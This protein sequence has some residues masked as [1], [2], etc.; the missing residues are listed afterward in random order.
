[1]ATGHSVGTVF[2]ELDLDPSRYMKGQ[3]TLLKEAQNG[4]D[5]LEKNFKNLQ[6]KSDASYDLMRAQAVKSLEAIK[7][8]SQSTAN[9]IIRAEKAKADQLTR[10]NEQQY[11]KQ[12]GFME[13]MKGGWVDLAAK[14][15]LVRQ[16]FGVAEWLASPF[17]MGLKAVDEYNQSVASL[18]AMVTTFGERQ[19]GMS[20]ADQ[21]VDALA[22][23]KAMIP[24][25]EN[26]AAKTLLSGQETTALANAFARSGVF[27]DANNAKQVESFTRI[28]NA[29]PLMTQG[30]EI[31]RQINTEIRGLMTGASAATNMMLTTL[32]AIDPEIE[33]H[34]D[35]WRKE[36]TVL[37]HVGELLSGFGPAT[38]LLENNWQAVKTNIETI[39]MQ[40]MRAMMGG[41]YTFLIDKAKELGKAMEG[42]GLLF[43]L[44]A[45]NELENKRNALLKEVENQQKLVNYLKNTPA[46]RISAGPTGVSETEADLERLKRELL[47]FSAKMNSKQYPTPPKAKDPGKTEEELEKERKAAEKALK[48]IEKA[49]QE[50]YRLTI[51]QMEYQQDQQDK[52]DEEN[53]K[54]AIKDRDALIKIQ[55]DLKKE[56][57]KL[58]ADKTEA[59]KTM[60]KDLS[61]YGYDSYDAEIKLLDERAKKYAETTG[62]W[63]LSMEWL[64]AMEEQTNDKRILES[65]TYFEGVSVGLRDLERDY[66]K[67]AGNTARLGAETMSDLHSSFSNI[68]YDGMRGKM[69]SLS[70]YWNTF[71]ENLKAKFFKIV[72]D[73]AAQKIIMGFKSAWAGEPWG[74]GTIESMLGIDVPFLSFAGGGTVPGAWNG[75]GGFAGDSVPAMLT[76]GEYVVRREVAQDPMAGQLIRALNQDMGARGAVAPGANIPGLT[77][78][79]GLYEGGEVGHYGFF[80]KIFS[81]ITKI[82]SPITKFFESTLGKV[83]GGAGML[84]VG[85]LFPPFIPAMLAGAALGGGMSA[86][87]GGDILSGAIMGGLGSAAGQAVFGPSSTVVK[88]GDQWKVVPTDQVVNIGNGRAIVSSR[89]G[90]VMATL[91]ASNL[92]AAWGLTSQTVYSAAAGAYQ[93]IATLPQAMAEFASST[94]KFLDW[95]N[96]SNLPGA[97]WDTIKNFDTYSYISDRLPSMLK[98]FTLGLA[99]MT[100]GGMLDGSAISGAMGIGQGGTF[101]AANGTGPQGLPYTGY[102]YG[103]QGEIVKTRSESDR[104]RS[105]FGG[106]LVIHVYNQLDGKVVD[107]FEKRIKVGAETVIINR[108]ARNMSSSTQ[109]VYS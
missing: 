9:D 44:G 12:I 51:Q 58:L 72:A 98:N 37:E 101:A 78:L 88:I 71:T 39:A 22:Y 70:D 33:K 35:T 106:D 48:A 18:A 96:L 6:I 102:F 91:P 69:N 82:L 26:I 75:R 20:F 56:D 105:G 15:Y 94:A 86:L 2:V 83:L 65:G 53:Y 38:A 66:G 3:Q 89:L 67:W 73:I 79:A 59:Y 104:E 92:E 10:I 107:H 7:N 50:H 30:Q 63:A 11:G 109:R 61:K 16:A 97:A 81:P 60:Y 68:F 14:V 57:E 42:V 36:G 76:P 29:L 21:W 64:R 93:T 49:D 5:R 99:G 46:G 87:T 52:L 8:S 32:K 43:N 40:S 90:D 103:H 4:A 77:G 74:K 47:D 54:E 19:A 41:S 85:A 27:L 100:G 23:S 34:L 80:S 95:K 84:A 28:S 108:N 55:E 31:M 45:Q 25:L 13:K 24:I 17:I 62:D 1:M